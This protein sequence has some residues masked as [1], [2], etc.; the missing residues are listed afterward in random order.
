MSGSLQPW[1]AAAVRRAYGV[2]DV[3][4]LAVCCDVELPQIL[5]VLGMTRRRRR[6]PY[7]RSGIAGRA[8]CRR[9]YGMRR[10]APPSRAAG[11]GGRDDAH[12]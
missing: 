7:V 9:P 4:T 11:R 5:S 12:H 3:H 1:Q 10:L 6:R 8:A 2:L